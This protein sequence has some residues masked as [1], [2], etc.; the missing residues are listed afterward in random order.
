[1]EVMGTD[2]RGAISCAPLALY[3]GPPEW[4]FI[5]STTKGAARRTR[6][7]GVERNNGA[8]RKDFVEG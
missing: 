2:I 7:L 8:T 1:M 6:S 3:Q 4:L 5:S